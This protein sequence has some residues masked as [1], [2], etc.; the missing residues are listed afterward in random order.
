[1]TTAEALF[2]PDGAP[3]RGLV[4]AKAPVSGQ[5][6]TRLGA[7]VGL[8]VAARL[9]AA[10]LLDT[11]DAFEVA[12]GPGHRHVAM[13]G[14]LA[15]AAQGE[16]IRDRLA[17]WTVHEQRGDG[18]GE[19]LANAHADVAATGPGPVVQVGMDTPQV[20]ARLLEDVVTRL[21]GSGPPCWGRPRTVA[22]GCWR[23]P[24]ARGL[25]CWS[26]VPMSTERTCRG[27]RAAR[28]WRPGSRSPT[29]PVLCD[30]DTVVEADRGRRR[31]PDHALRP[32]LARGHAVASPHLRW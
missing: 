18:L 14:D 1:M 21:A 2:G 15:A 24:T 9:A 17:S 3:A 22:G 32:T 28:W 25:R 12:F 31:R 27:D 6:K 30:V 10:A 19:R 11:L 29:P 20:T 5:V 13:T 8:D 26:S 23:W 7:D 4:V 16:E